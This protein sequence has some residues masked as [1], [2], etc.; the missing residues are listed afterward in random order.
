MGVEQ[1]EIRRSFALEKMTLAAAI[2]SI[3]VSIVIFFLGR[4]PRLSLE[5]RVYS[6]HNLIDIKGVEDLAVKLFY[7]GSLVDNF[8]VSHIDMVN[9]GT[10]TVL[11]RG[12]RTDLID[13]SFAISASNNCKIL[14]IDLKKNDVAWICAT[15]NLIKIYFDQWRKDEAISFD[16][17]SEIRHGAAGPQFNICG[18]PIVGGAAPIVYCDSGVCSKERMGT[19][20]LTF[21]LPVLT[22]VTTCLAFVTSLQN[23]RIRKG[24]YVRI[25]A[26]LG[27]QRLLCK[28]IKVL[29]R[30]LARQAR[31]RDALQEE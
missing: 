12:A 7:K 29:Q 5:T 30:A 1:K 18:R 6:P 20:L 4:P 19:R 28:K 10:G 17:F 11:G 8:W 27:N 9:V 3:L 21:I 31:E 15:N 24:Q 23:K 22:L 26:L 13:E 16:V 14:G 2:F 25:E